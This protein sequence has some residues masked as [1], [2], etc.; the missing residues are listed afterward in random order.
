MRYF[1]ATFVLLTG[2]YL[3]CSAAMTSWQGTFFV[4]NS[5]YITIRNPAYVQKFAEFSELKGKAWNLLSRERLLA[6]AFPIKE[7][8]RTGFVFGH[9]IT[10]DEQGR[11]YFACDLYNKVEL[12]F[13]AEGIMESG[14]FSLMKVQ[15][16]CHANADLNTLE[17]VWI[18]QKE[19]LSKNPTP[20]L[21]FDF[22]NLDVHISFTNL[23]SQWPRQWVLQEVKLSQDLNVIPALSIDAKEITR[24]AKSPMNLTW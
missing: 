17:P 15:A 7:A 9:F 2:L 3:G 6:E 22:P 11:K 1:F 13:V 19:I 16:P 12:T 18:P 14:E 24:S 10:Q 4:S 20:T 23:A 8:D 5:K 21:K